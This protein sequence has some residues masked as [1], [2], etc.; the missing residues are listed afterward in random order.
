VDPTIKGI[1]YRRTN[2]LV[3]LPA[4]PK[5]LTTLNEAL[6]VNAGQ[7]DVD[8]IV[9]TISYDKSLAAQCLRVANSV[10]YRQRGDV[11]TVREAV[12][13]LG[14]WRVRDLAFSCN[15]PLLF[16]GLNCVV[17][18]EMFWRHALATGYVSQKLS[19]E[20]QNPANEQIYLAG[21][22]H[23][24]GI[25]INAVLFPEDFCTILQE[26]ARERSPVLPIEQRV[27]GFTHAESGRIL[28]DLWKLPIEVA[29]VIE[30]HHAPEQQITNNEATLIVELANRLCW[31]HGLGYGYLLAETAANEEDVVHE[32]RER[33]AK[34]C[35]PTDRDYGR[36]LEAHMV[37]ARE[38]ADQV[39]GLQPVRG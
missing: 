27:L 32:L 8:K 19:M 38:L 26:A 25:L 7:A 11:T 30:F 23:D 14:L 6:S 22:L 37:A 9:R 31:K 35:A 3:N 21:L 20:F 34:A 12:L 29:E 13:S 39:F 36:V 33:F 5:I 2:H 16:C 1:L 10:L 15:L 4:M 17:P 18:K 28:A 24:I